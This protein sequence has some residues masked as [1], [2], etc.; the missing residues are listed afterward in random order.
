Y[1]PEPTPHKYA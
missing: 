1:F